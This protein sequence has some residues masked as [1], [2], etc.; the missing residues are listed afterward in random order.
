M[1]DAS[2][3]RW[4][5]RGATASHPEM[6]QGA[7]ALRPEMMSLAPEMKEISNADD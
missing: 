5:G 1:S 3:K 4:I 7:T 6:M 2:E